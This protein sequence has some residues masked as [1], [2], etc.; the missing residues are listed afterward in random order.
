MNVFSIPFVNILCL[1]EFGELKFL[2]EVWIPNARGYEDYAE[3]ESWSR[4]RNV[5]GWNVL[6]NGKQ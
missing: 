2:P 5:S 1:G 4:D 3:F 6:L